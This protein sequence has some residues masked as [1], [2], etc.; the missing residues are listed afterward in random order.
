MADG[1]PDK[2]LTKAKEF[3]KGRLQL[4]MED[5]RAVA[6]WLGGQELLRREILTVDEVLAIVDGVIGREPAARGHRAVAPRSVPPGR[7]RPVPLGDPFP[8]AAGRLTAPV[9]VAIARRPAAWT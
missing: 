2:E 8:E 3:I 9:R 1:V 4:R 7:R 6:S 5:T